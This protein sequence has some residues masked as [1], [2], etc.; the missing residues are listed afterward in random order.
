[1]HDE[2]LDATAGDM[3]VLADGTASGGPA[4]S[5]S[6]AVVATDQDHGLYVSLCRV[7][8]SSQCHEHQTC[9]VFMNPYFSRCSMPRVLFFIAMGPFSS[10]APTIADNTCQL[11][12]ICKMGISALTKTTPTNNQQVM[13]AVISSLS[14]VRKR[15]A[16]THSQ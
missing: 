13:Y 1:M 8:L 11:L 10:V 4:S 6:L 15:F 16:H 7:G 2:F 3:Q 9:T 5:S 12:L 14:F